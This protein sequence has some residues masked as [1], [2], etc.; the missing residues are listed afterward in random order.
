MGW[1]LKSIPAKD[2]PEIAL[3]VSKSISNRL[4]IIGA[5]GGFSIGDEFISTADDTLLMQNALRAGDGP[6]FLGNAGTAMRFLTSYFSL[7]PGIRQLYGTDEMHRRPIRPL[8]NALRQIGAQ[9]E[10]ID[11]NEFPPLEIIGGAVSGSDD[12]VEI[13]ADISSQFISS[14]ALIA[15]YIENGLRIKWR[16][17]LVSEPYLN[18]TLNLMEMSG[19]SNSRGPQFIKIKPGKYTRQPTDVSAAD[20][21]SAGY[22]IAHSIL[23]QKAINLLELQCDGLQADENLLHALSAAGWLKW[24]SLDSGIRVIP[25]GS[26]PA[27]INLDLSAWPDSVPVLCVLCAATGVSLT[28]KGIS[29]L[30]FK[31]S[32]RMEVLAAALRCGGAVV[33]LHQD[34]YSQAGRANFKHPAQLKTHA[35]HRMAMAFSLLMAEWPAL[36]IDDAGCVTKSFPNFWA[37]LEKM[38]YRLIEDNGRE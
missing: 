15:P 14:L 35:D 19:V 17:K 18:Q 5:L 34:T 7:T 30:Q 1:R 11:K 33:D 13:S 10:Y 38:G 6:I 21:S 29:H 20:W 12:W 2:F 23:Q 31:E 26:D 27:S 3:P 8:V 28:L 37:E 4:L 16:G 25:G 24:Q 22:F 36:S 32:N 9:I